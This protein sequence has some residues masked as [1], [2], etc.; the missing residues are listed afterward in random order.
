MEKVARPVATPPPAHHELPTFVVASMSQHLTP[1]A[2]LA[3][4]GV[5]E[6][7]QGEGEDEDSRKPAPSQKKNAQKVCQESCQ[8]TA[9]WS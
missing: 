1:V 5:E 9:S 7:V 2:P 3:A 6:N 4:P 8:T